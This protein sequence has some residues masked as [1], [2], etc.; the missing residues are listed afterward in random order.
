[1]KKFK[2][3]ELEFS[4]A[5]ANYKLYL[6][7]HPLEN[8]IDI[9][10]ADALV[11][12]TGFSDYDELQLLTL[13]SLPSYRDSVLKNIKLSKPKPIF[14]VDLPPAK[15]LRKDKNC[16][17]LLNSIEAAEIILPFSLVGMYYPLTLPLFLPLIS[18]LFHLINLKSKNFAK[19]NSY[20][21]LSLFYSGSGLRSAISAKKIE[22][23]IAPELRKRKG[24]KPNILIEYGAGHVDLKSYLSHKKLR[25][26]VIEFHKLL[27]FIPYDKNYV[28]QICEINFDEEYGGIGKILSKKYY[29]SPCNYVKILYEI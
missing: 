18:E 7:L 10:N 9:A 19:I 14:F 29:R 6:C 21:S 3:K 20:L 27:N 26:F 17:F 23:H 25:N 28:N 13:L 15:F 11:L 24:D 4:T 22:E 8:E 12:E 16:Y 2:P 5:S 1:M